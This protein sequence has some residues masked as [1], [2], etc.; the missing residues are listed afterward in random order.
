MKFYDKETSD[1][2]KL[3]NVILHT[4]DYGLKTFLYE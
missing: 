4:N 3:T 2:I 1:N